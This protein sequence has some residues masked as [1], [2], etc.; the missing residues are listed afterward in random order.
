MTSKA[1]SAQLVARID[2]YTQRLCEELLRE[3]NHWDTVSLMRNE[4]HENPAF[5]AVLLRV[6]HVEDGTQVR[7]RQMASDRTR[8]T[9]RTQVR[10]KLQPDEQTEYDL[11]FDRDS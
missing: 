1:T 2:S 5:A 8:R 10:R 7:L 9:D 4:C 6:I 11:Q 3:R